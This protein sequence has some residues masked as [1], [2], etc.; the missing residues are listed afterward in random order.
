MGG[1]ALTDVL[2]EAK[3]GLPLRDGALVAELAHGTCRW[4]HRLEFFLQRLMARPLK[5]RERALH[6][7]LLVGLYQLAETRVP[8][9]AA[10]A[11]TSGAAGLLGRGW[12]TGLVNAV[13]RRYL[14]TS[15]AL[16]VQARSEPVARWS[17]PGWFIQA[18][19]AAWPGQASAL[20]EGLLGRP[21]FTLRVDLSRTTLAAQARE[22]ARAGLASRP[23]PGVA[24]ALMLERP[25]PVERLPGFGDG[26]VSVQD[27]GAQLAAPLLD[28]AP[29]QRVLDACA[30]PGG[31]SGHILESAPVS[32]VAMDR[33][34]TRLARVRENLERLGRRAELVAGDAAA[35]SGGWIGSGF[36]RILADVPCTATGVMRRHP[37]I[38]LL[39]RAS[40]VPALVARQA[41]ILDA[42]WRLLRPG[43]KLLYATCSLLPEENE[44][45]VE[46]FLQRHGEAVALPLE[47]P[48]GVPAGPGVQ[49]LP[50]T[51]ETDG[52][53]YALLQKRPA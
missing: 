9:H 20:L 38:R 51:R 44:R 7:L 27:A 4:F 48:L 35:P 42:L 1:R 43:G 47:T 12:A 3:K 22:L 19:E 52:F 10:V 18:V 53:F 33:D 23:V 8:P 11:A 14:E 25:V 41:A 24:S 16:A 39:R 13:L 26:L 21:P 50:V 2:P 6:A 5:A 17:Q 32:L 34:R 45:Q 37:D 28:L 49:L 29:G 36:D 46:A 30:A 40:D 31:K 15:E